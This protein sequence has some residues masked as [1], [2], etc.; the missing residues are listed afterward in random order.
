MAHPKLEL[1][2]QEIDDIFN[3]IDIDGDGEIDK[4]EME[5][6]IKVLMIMQDDLSFKKADAYFENKM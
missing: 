6:F 5:C 1:S 4:Q 2:A 3:I